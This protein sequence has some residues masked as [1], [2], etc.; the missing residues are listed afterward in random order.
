MVPDMTLGSSPGPCDAMA[1]GGCA[2]RSD[3][4]SPGGAKPPDT[5]MVLGGGTDISLALGGIMSHGHQHIA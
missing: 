3:L 5:N 4:Y 2:V 1:L